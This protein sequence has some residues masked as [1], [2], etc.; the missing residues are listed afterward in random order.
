MHHLRTTAV[1]LIL[2]ALA[3]AVKCFGSGLHSKHRDAWVLLQFRPN[4]DENR[5]IL[6]GNNL[7]VLPI[8]ALAAAVKG[9]GSGLH[10]RAGDMWALLLRPD[11]LLL[12]YFK[13]AAVI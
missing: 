8:Q 13:S 11:L 12:T 7:F 9:V 6:D 3:A 2:Q 10:S 1:R 5:R 4:G